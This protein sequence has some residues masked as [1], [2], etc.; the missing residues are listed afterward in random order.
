MRRH[1][2]LLA[3]A[4]G[5]LFYPAALR[6]W[7]ANGHR[8]VGEIAQN[9]LGPEA[10]QEVRRLLSGESLAR[11]SDWADRIRSRPEEWAHTFPWHYINVGDEE[12]LESVER[13]PDG[14]VLSAIDQLSAVLRDPEAGFEQ[15]ADALRLLVH[16][17]GDLHQ[18]LHVGR[19]EDRGGNDIDVEW[20]GE[21]ENLH[22]VWD[23]GILERQRLS[24]TE[25]VRFI[26]HPSNEEIRAWQASSPLEWAEESQALRSQVYDFGVQRRT[27]PPPGPGLEGQSAEDEPLPRLSWQYLDRNQDVVERR[28]LQAGIRLAGWLEAIF[29]PAASPLEDD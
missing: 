23:S 24:Y 4:L 8:V 25:L 6:A 11:V 14:D 21:V 9:H 12:K 26:D 3:L 18:P 2:L 16:F 10:E 1:T 22:R 13:H 29:A 20:F 15:Q 27:T 7:G 17:I 19:A 28:L 5:F